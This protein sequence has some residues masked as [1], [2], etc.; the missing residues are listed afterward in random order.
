[1]LY[2]LIIPA[3]ILLGI[4]IQ[5]GRYLYYKKKFKPAVYN[6]LP[7]LA[8]TRSAV[9][10]LS[11]AIQIVTLSSED[12]SLEDESKFKEFK[13]FLK[14]RY[15]VL[16]S[17][18]QTFY[19]GTRSIIFYIKGSDPSLLPSCQMSHFDV[20]EPG[21]L[22]KW[23]Y[24]P[25]SGAI[26]EGF[27]WGRGTQDIKGHLIALME[28]MEALLTAETIPLRDT[29]FAFGGDEEVGGTRGAATNVAFFKERNIKFEY[30]LDEGAAI[31]DGMIG[32]IKRP[33]AMI[34]ISE[35]GRA[36]IKLETLGAPGHSA[37]PPAH[38]TAGIISKAVVNVERHP[39]RK[40][41]NY[42]VSQM[43]QALSAVA[44]GAIGFLLANNK[45]YSPILLK[46]LGKSPS[47]AAMLHTTQAVTMLDSG[48]RE[49]IIPE[50]ASAMMNLR[51]I[52]GETIDSVLAHV[53][54]AVGNDQV[55]VDI[56]GGFPGSNPVPPSDVNSQAFKLL[57]DTVAQTLPGVPAIPY[58]VTAATDS[59]SYT[60]LTSNILRF[61]PVIYAPED[62]AGIHGFN[63]R[64]SLYSF[65]LCIEF[66]KNL[67]QK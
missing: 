66:F 64:I 43:L 46:I 10:N 41:L 1:M 16:H 42:S 34:G 30:V 13:N 48:V 18:A 38:T 63:E 8:A 49:N 55:T 27:I 51:I 6:G 36:N 20:V 23:K 59:R 4:S 22:S 56:S 50:Q 47:I 5:I 32:F 29:Y 15:P 57:S 2:L 54:K 31:V 3:L 61:T 44:P 53:K 58:M 21:D 67:F 7:S 14:T 9:S 17:H 24:P 45:F 40:S 35:K 26:K 11:D 28:A 60:G 19:P 25:F 33:L 37:M 65:G 39:F 62:L 52:P 12:P